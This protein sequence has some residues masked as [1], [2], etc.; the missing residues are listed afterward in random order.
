MKRNGPGLSAECGQS[1]GIEQHRKWPTL[2]KYSNELTNQL[3]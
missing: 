2:R 3:Q 1:Y